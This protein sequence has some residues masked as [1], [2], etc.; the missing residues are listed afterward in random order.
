MTSDLKQK[1]RGASLVEPKGDAVNEY[2]SG[3]RRTPKKLPSKLFY[4][5]NGNRLFDEICR[6]DEYYPTRMEFTILRRNLPE[7]SQLAGA[8]AT[9]VELGS[10]T[11][12][13]ARLLLEHLRAPLA[14]V[15]VE[16][17]R[18]QLIRSCEE[19]QTD[20]PELK[21]FPVC[22]DYT[23]ELRLPP[24]PNGHSNEDGRMFMFFPGSTL[25]NFEPIEALAFLLKLAQVGGGGSGLLI[26]IDLKKDSEVLEAAYNDRQ[27]I[28]AAFNL[29]ILARAN[30]E[31][32]A[33]FQ[34][35]QFRH[36]AFYEPL[37]GRVVMQLESLCDQEV[38]IGREPFYF[39][40][41][42]RITTEY[43][44][45][46]SIGEFRALARLAGFSPQ[47]LWTDPDEMFSLHYLT[48]A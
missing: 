18:T 32:A 8:G 28:T 13:K 38:Q 7:I 34:L 17:S 31:L 41:A 36:H 14:Y 16:I 24:L 3:L 40:R 12:A 43:S 22:T 21:I 5:D 27:G 11:P 42:E 4:D 33:N 44:Y 30:R 10:G 46:Y 1:H 35:D 39:R 15:P 25:G 19:L 29:N 2:L 26:G 23:G 20:Y 6:L 45:K 47:V 48:V 9:L 37:H